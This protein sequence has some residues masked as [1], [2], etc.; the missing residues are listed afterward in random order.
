MSGTIKVLLLAADPDRGTSPLRVDREIRGAVEAARM[1]GASNV[2]SIQ[3]ELAVC[4]DDLQPAL[5]RHEPHIVH[6]A[7][8]GSQGDGLLLD[9]GSRVATAE[10]VALFG[11]FPR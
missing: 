9:D 5:L 7:A 8:H 11:S 1:G 6:F 4:P 3:E 2:V 10:L